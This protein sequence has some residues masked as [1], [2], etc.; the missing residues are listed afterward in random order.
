MGEQF[1]ASKEV[2]KMKGGVIHLDTPNEALSCVVVVT[3]GWHSEVNLSGDNWSLVVF[4]KG[5][6][7]RKRQGRQ[8]VKQFL[9]LLS[10]ICST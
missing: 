3:D 1:S 4:W 6:A 7:G 5:H 2:G 9:L 10:T 8:E